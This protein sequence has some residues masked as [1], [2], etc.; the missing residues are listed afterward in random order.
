MIFNWFDASEAAR[1]GAALASSA[2]GDAADQEPI[3]RTAPD[4]ERRGHERVVP[5]GLAVQRPIDVEH[6]PREAES[7]AVDQEQI[8]RPPVPK[9]GIVH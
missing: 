3:E 9:P 6:E 8:A 5:P 1:I 4:R 2:H 7:H